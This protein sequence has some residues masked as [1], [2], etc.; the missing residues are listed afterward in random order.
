MDGGCDQAK[1]CGNAGEQQVSD[2]EE[3]GIDER[4]A[5]DPVKEVVAQSGL[6]PILLGGE[7]P[8]AKSG[9][10]HAV[11][12]SLQG[13]VRFRPSE[14]RDAEPDCSSERRRRQH[15]PGEGVRVILIQW[16]EGEGWVNAVQ[17][18]DDR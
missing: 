16:G 7:G 17:R 2:A 8:P 9:G 15:E 13:R 6:V 1:A 5:E 4:E 10:A 18:A 3:Q 12:E 14:Q 11:V